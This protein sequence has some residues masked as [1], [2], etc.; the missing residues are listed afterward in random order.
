M[1]TLEKVRKFIEGRVSVD[2]EMGSFSNDDDIFKLGLVSS[3]FAMQ[4]V[5][6]VETE[7]KISVANEDL[8]LENFCSVANI[9]RFVER[10]RE[11][12]SVPA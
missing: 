12:A 5:A 1:M 7:F 8:S 11:R 10:K 9:A 2:E 3:L 6:F 4:I